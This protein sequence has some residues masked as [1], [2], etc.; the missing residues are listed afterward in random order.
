M[1][2][3]KFTGTYEKSNGGTELMF[4]RLMN[5]LTEE[6]KNKYQIICSRIREF[7]P[8]K[9]KVIYWSHDLYNDP[10]SFKLREPEI[11]NRIDACVF[12]SDWQRITFET[13]HGIP[14]HKNYVIRNG[15]ENIG[16][17]P[18]RVIK[19]P[20]KFIYH[21]T[22]HRGLE[23]LLPVFIELLKTHPD[24]S[25]DVYSSFAAYGWEERDKHYQHLIDI[26]KNHPNINYH[27]FQ[28]NDIV[29]K[30]L[31]ETDVYAYPCIWTETSCLS[32]IEALCSGCVVVTNTLG[33]LPETCS[34][35]N[36][37]IMYKYHEDKNTHANIFYS[38]LKNYLDSNEEKFLLDR[39]A[40]ARYDWNL[41]KN[42]WQTLL[43]VLDK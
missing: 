9:E 27:G 26:C 12:V 21:T 39:H 13:A 20:K 35:F 18:P 14:H 15:I 10:E 3:D 29:R 33:A 7:D 5:S 1:E 38:I 2:P 24:I 16:D 30:A 31:L 19:N 4:R 17:I 11:I 34:G 42:Q 32:V 6:Q 37:T 25:L 23:I 8:T 40:P 41:I 22:P 36:T 28:P 43:K